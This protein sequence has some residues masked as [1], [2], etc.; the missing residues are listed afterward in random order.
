M[1]ECE[2]CLN[3][4]PIDCFEFF[5]CTHKICLFC[6]IKMVEINKTQFNELN[7]PFC[8]T[9]T[10]RTEKTDRTDRTDRTE[11]TE[12]TERTG[13]TNIEINNELTETNSDIENYY[14]YEYD[15]YESLTKKN[16]KLI[17]KKLKK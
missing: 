14:D 5:S 8:R 12:R 9:G 6:Y 16:I 10:D 2:L 7:C 1:V 11:R 13:R 3:Q 4:F 17:K 15:Y